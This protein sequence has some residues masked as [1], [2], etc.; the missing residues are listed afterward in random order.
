MNR[1][2]AKAGIGIYIT[3]RVNLEV[4]DVSVSAKTANIAIPIQ[5]EAA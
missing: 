2:T 4:I 3:C 1:L 5:A